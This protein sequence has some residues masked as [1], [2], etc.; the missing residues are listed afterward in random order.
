MR[1]SSAAELEGRSAGDDAEHIQMLV[2]RCNIET[3]LV[4]VDFA[5]LSSL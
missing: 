1:F 2:T 4:V 5:E 3:G